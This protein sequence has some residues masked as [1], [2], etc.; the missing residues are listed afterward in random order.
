MTKIF[1]DYD[2]EQLNAQY[3][4]R[5]LV[6]DIGPY[7]AEAQEATKA[8]REEFDC[9]SCYQYGPAE[10]QWMVVYRS[11]K[12]AVAPAPLLLYFHG[13]AWLM[14]EEGC[15]GQVVPAF[16][17]AGAVLGAPNFSVVPDVDLGTMVRQCREAVAH[18]FENAD[19]LGIDEAQ[20]HVCGHSS[21]AHLA[22]MVAVT[23]WQDEFGLPADLVKSAAL[24]SGPYDLAPVR[25]S[26]RNDYLY[27]NAD[28]VERFSPGRHIRVDAP[29]AVF[30]Y[31]GGEL[32]E[33]QRQ[34]RDL[35]A[36]W[37]A[38][39]GRASSPITFPNNNHFEMRAEYGRAGSPLVE[40]VLELIGLTQ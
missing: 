5:T 39:T 40:A 2:Q 3:N 11:K 7:S 25:L 28:D 31:G 12:A 26:A 22:A 10:D 1:G 27:L 36:A 4:Q 38:A 32:D 6:P 16:V 24:V 13:G 21:G 33:F 29:P 34:S 15:D 14:T 17:R 20:I 8:A 35:A 18:C 37:E 9:D 19:K 30:A 23:D